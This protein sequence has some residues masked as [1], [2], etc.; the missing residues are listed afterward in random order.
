MN[1]KRAVAIFSCALMAFSSLTG[2]GISANAEDTETW[3]EKTRESSSGTV[4][5]ENGQLDLGTPHSK[6]VYFDHQYAIGTGVEDFSDAEGSAEG[7]LSVSG[8]T[9]EMQMK[10][11]K[12]ENDTGKSWD[13]AFTL[14]DKNVGAYFWDGGNNPKQICLTYSVD[15][16]TLNDRIVVSG[17]STTNGTGEPSKFGL[18]DG[19]WHK[20]TFQAGLEGENKIIVIVK[21]DDKEVFAGKFDSSDISEGY[22]AI[23]TNDNLPVSLSVKD[24][25]FPSV[26]TPSESN[27]SNPT[28]SEPNPS[29]PA[30]SEPAP[31]NPTPSEPTPS[32]EQKGKDTDW[33]NSENQTIQS[34]DGT[35][36]MLP[37]TFVYNKNQYTMGKGNA[38]N[39]DIVGGTY[40][41]DI[42]IDGRTSDG[43]QVAFALLDQKVG[44]YFWDA[45]NKPQ[46]ICLQ[47]SSAQKKFTDV[48][49]VDSK[50]T[51]AMQNI[52]AVS[53]A[54]STFDIADGNWHNLT[55]KVGIDGAESDPHKMLVMVDVDGKTVYKALWNNNDVDFSNVFA[56]GNFAIY[57]N[58]AAFGDFKV[59]VREVNNGSGNGSGSPSTGENAE[60][61][62]VP[63]MMATMAAGLIAVFAVRK[64]KS[65]N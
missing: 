40:S 37:E 8:G 34:A 64:R 41:F 7:K 33:I 35:F 62:I 36:Q 29:N 31:S 55:F 21:V 20:V 39:S 32:E 16:D 60:K 4:T 51:S 50:T 13:F 53:D 57:T 23:Y 30:P 42:K 38:E 24:V 6:V 44:T 59:S 3:I 48:V 22:F 26:T 12:A 1:R 28:P 56:K 52:Y 65:F 25:T 9:V 61:A 2:F 58:N 19:E 10:I 49:A 54:P 18:D 27:P 5:I 46:Q 17:T 43:W 14:L 15:R 63:V 11:D 47:Y 45:G